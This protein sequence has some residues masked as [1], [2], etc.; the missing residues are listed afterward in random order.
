MKRYTAEEIAEIS[1]LHRMWLRGETGGVR[2]NLSGAAL[3]YAD[4]SWINLSEAILSKAD[5]SRANLNGACLEYAD[6]S[7]AKLCY[8]NLVWTNLRGA[9]LR[10]ADL[11]N[12]ILNG[13]F[14]IGT[15]LDN[16]ILPTFQ[17]VPETGPFDGWKKLSDDHIAHLRIPAGAGRVSSTGRK[18]R[19]EYVKVIAIYTPD[20]KKVAKL[21][22]V[23]GHRD[24]QFMYSPGKIIR[25]DKWDPDIREECTHGIHFFLTRKEAEEY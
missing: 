18:C 17:I 22:E 7:E 11:S 14:L 25:P 5:L 15:R 16:A 12:A 6:I 24:N 4:L 8:A 23:G 9:S 20:G 1:R 13:A 19:A 10:G 21:T 3:Y 2:A